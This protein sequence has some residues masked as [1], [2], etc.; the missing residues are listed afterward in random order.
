MV[1]ELEKLD[2]TKLPQDKLRDL[3]NRAQFLL[4]PAGR[5]DDKPAE[6]RDADQDLVVTEL[7]AVLAGRG[8]RK[9]PL[10]VLLKS[11]AGKFFRRGVK[12][13]M[14]YIRESFKP[15]CKAEVVK[16]VRLILRCIVRDLNRRSIPVCP[17]TICQGLE[18]VQTVVERSYPGYATA[19]LLPVV[20]KRSL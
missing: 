16:V 4:D 9:L 10:P 13:T 7:E 1:A 14:V 6:G 19:G 18:R 15:T 17:K 11:S 12:T 8:F 3:V 2:L 20:L 5:G